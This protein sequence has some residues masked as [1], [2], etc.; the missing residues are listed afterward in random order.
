ME[1]WTTNCAS[2]TG[3]VS[4][5]LADQCLSFSFQG[6]GYLDASPGSCGN[7][8]DGRPSGPGVAG[9]GQVVGALVVVVSVIVMIML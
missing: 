7:Y 2:R 9:A 1:R 4:I 5:S 8:L 6:S 3:F